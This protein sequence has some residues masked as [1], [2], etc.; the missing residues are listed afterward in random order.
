MLVKIKPVERDTTFIEIC[1]NES[2]FLCNTNVATNA[3]LECMD[4]TDFCKTLVYDVRLKPM[5]IND[6]GVQYQCVGDSV[7]YTHLDVY[8]R[9]VQIYF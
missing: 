3:I 2:V 8:K 1:P 6:L 9:Q 4:P 5:R 7:S